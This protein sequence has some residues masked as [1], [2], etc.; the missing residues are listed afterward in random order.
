MAQHRASCLVA[1]C[2]L[3]GVS[4][5]PVRRRKEQ[6]VLD[7]LELGHIMARQLVQL[8]GPFM[9]LRAFQRRHAVVQRQESIRPKAG[10]CFCHLLAM[11]LRR[12]QLASLSLHLLAYKIGTLIDICIVLC[13]VS[14]IKY[15]FNGKC[16][17]FS[18]LKKFFLFS[19][20]F[21]FFG[22]WDLSP[23]NQGSKLHPLHWKEVLTTGPPG[24]SFSFLFMKLSVSSVFF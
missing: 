10:S 13:G 16:Y 18:P 4:P 6:K 7:V 11:D 14:E 3:R 9:Q 2:V 23:P 5:P 17:Q 19:F 20:C 22:V 12:S 21:L 1:I 8:A 15:M 24:D